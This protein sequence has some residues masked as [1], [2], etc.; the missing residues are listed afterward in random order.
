VQESAGIMTP[1]IAIKTPE[2]RRL[3]APTF[4]VKI[5]Y[6]VNCKLNK[7]YIIL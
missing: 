5:I 7:Y 1:F 4:K 3:L 6:Q 2:E